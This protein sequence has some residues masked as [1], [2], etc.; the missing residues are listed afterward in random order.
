M[1][2]VVA[3]AK[4]ADAGIDPAV[5]DLCLPIRKSPRVK[6]DLSLAVAL[7]GPELDL[8]QRALTALEHHPDCGR[9]PEW[10]QQNLAGIPPPCWEGDL[11]V[12]RI[13][14]QLTREWL[15]RKYRPILEELLSAEAGSEVRLRVDAAPPEQSARRGSSHASRG[16]GRAKQSEPS[17]GQEAAEAD[18]SRPRKVVVTGSLRA[19]LAEQLNTI[20]LNPR[21]TFESFVTGE[22]NRFAHSAA[23][24]VAGAPGESYNPLFIHGGVGLGKT[25]LAHAIGHEVQMQRPN[26]VVAYL[27]GEAF[28]TSFVAAIRE[29]RM[30]E[31]RRLYRMVDVWLVDD[32]Q[33]IAA[34]ERTGEEFFHIF[35]ALHGTSRQVVICSDRPPEDLQILDERMVSRFEGGLVTDIVS[36]SYETRLAILQQ[37]VDT[38]S[39]R[40]PDDVLEMMARMIRSNVRVLEGALIRVLAHASFS[41]SPITLQMASSLLSRH[42]DDGSRAPV[43]VDTV[44]RVVSDTLDVPVEALMGRKRDRRSLVA[45]QMAMFLT[46]ELTDCSLEQIGQLFGGKD[47][48]TVA[49]A[50]RSFAGAIDADVELERLTARV[51]DRVRRAK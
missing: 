13:S 22:S 42:F 37:K 18:V 24:A 16:A 44:Q 26:A 19:R 28:T 38:E 45:R 23:C 25:H 41:N 1:Q 9:L 15:D 31:F 8:W 20:P 14:S 33:F 12:V 11:L 46:R 27:S 40:I 32:V 29:R 2:G 48:S 6:D 21:Y 50:C 39:A 30:D 51:R 36:P 17:V 35:N 47:H 3:F 7:S 43:R 34:K 4:K 10:F 5:P 49:H